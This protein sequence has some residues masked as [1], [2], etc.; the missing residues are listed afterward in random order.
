MTY[1]PVPP[2]VVAGG[3][4]VP[5]MPP[6]AKIVTGISALASDGA[7][8]SRFFLAPQ[9]GIFSPDGQGYITGDAVRGVDYRKEANVS[10]YP[11]EQGAFAS[12]NKVKM[13]RECRIV[14]MNSGAGGLLGQLIPGLSLL[15]SISQLTGGLSIQAQMRAQLMTVLDVLV[16]TLTLVSVVTP[17]FTYSNMN[18][19]RHSYQRDARSGSASNIPL[20]V[21]LRE[22]RQTGTS[23]YKT[24]AQP[25]GA[26][27]QA[28]GTVQTAPP[29]VPEA[30]AAAPLVE[31]KAFAP[32]A[33]EST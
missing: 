14:F 16:D 5:A 20:E 7:F 29:T 26:D 8:I 23:T 25:D 6:G 4:G 33:I 2:T 1:V 28:K 15:S 31:P 3:P 17:E 10:D 32:G 27:A 13:P 21:S 9:W 18:V 30:K 11:V 24:T 22:I 19:V 12:Y